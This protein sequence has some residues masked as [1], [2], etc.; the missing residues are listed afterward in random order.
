MDSKA[1]SKVHEAIEAAG[2]QAVAVGERLVE[3]RK[4]REAAAEPASR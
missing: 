1:E 4:A 2:T 3:V